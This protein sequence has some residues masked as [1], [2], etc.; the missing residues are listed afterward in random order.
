MDR[1]QLITEAATG[2]T[3]YLTLTD[4]IMLSIHSTISDAITKEVIHVLSAL[5]LSAITHIIVKVATRLK[6]K[7]LT[8]TITKKDKSISEPSKQKENE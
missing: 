5:V 6:D 3:A 8:I 7:S 1:G 4:N 2:L